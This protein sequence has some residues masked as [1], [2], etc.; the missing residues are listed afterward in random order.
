MSLFH[1]TCM[2]IISITVLLQ[3]LNWWITMIKVP[4][5]TWRSC[6]WWS[7]N[8]DLV[9]P[10]FEQNGPK[11]LSRSTYNA[12]IL[13]CNLCWDLRHRR[14]ERLMLLDWVFRIE[15][16]TLARAIGSA[17]YTGRLHSSMTSRSSNA[18]PYVTDPDNGNGVV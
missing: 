7:F 16:S 13:S 8:Q 14:H 12:S 15:G 11:L 17:E 10:S 18:L 9:I 4:R 6:W 2:Q 3:L 5:G 1:G